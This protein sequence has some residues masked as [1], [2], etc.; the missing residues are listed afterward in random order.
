MSGWIKIHR[1]ITDHWIFQDAEKF[2]WWIDLLMMASHEDVKKIIGSQ[3]TE[4]KRGQLIASNSFLSERWKTSES[5]VR[6]YL[7]LLESDNMVVRCTNRKITIITICNYERYQVNESKGRTDER[8]DDEPM[9]NRWRSEY[10]NVEEDKEIYIDLTSAPASRTRE[11]NPA[12]D[13]A[14]ENGFVE[15]FK[16]QGSAILIMRVTGKSPEDVMRLLD[17]YLASR[18]MKDLGHKDFNHFLE[19]FQH[20][21]KNNKISIPVTPTQPKEKKVISGAD[22]LKVYG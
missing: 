4:L 3:L 13:E 15:R 12:W 5:S 8:S 14:R 1:E 6:R 20:A 9:M 11:E 16:A 17:V 19:A 22:V 7:G 10:K 21:I 2:K 18:Q